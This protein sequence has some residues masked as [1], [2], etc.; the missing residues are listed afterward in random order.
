MKTEPVAPQPGRIIAPDPN[1][2]LSMLKIP[3]FHRLMMAVLACCVSVSV[4]AAQAATDYTRLLDFEGTYEYAQGPTLQIAASP[5]AL[6]LQA[7]IAGA[8]YPLEPTDT[9]DVF[10]NV[11]D[12]RV[13]F[14]RDETGEVTGYRLL[15]DP[16]QP[17]FR[18][19]SADDV[20][21]KSMWYPRLAARDPG[22]RY[23]YTPPASP[24][25]GLPVGGLENS[26][27]T[28]GRV[29]ALVQKIISR[30]YPDVHSVL[31]AAGDKL[32]VEE[33][34]Y[35]YDRDALHQM[36]SATKSV[37]ALL[38]GMA[39]EQG[40]IESAKEPVLPY[41]EDEY[42]DLENVTD[43]K[44]QI[45]IED[46]LTQQS[47]LACNDWDGSSPGNETTM[48]NS[49]DWIRFVLNLPMAHAPGEAASYCSGGVKVLARLVEKQAGMPVEAFAETHLFEPL[50]IRDYR[51][52]FEPDSSSS[53]HFTQLYLR[54]RDM[55]KLGLLVANR[56]AWNEQQVI[57]R[58]W[59][60]SMTSAHSEL[61][62]TEY[63]YLWW[64]PYLNT[65]SGRHDAIAAQGNGGQEIYI[66]PKLNRVVVMTGGN[67]NRQSPSNRIFIEH[68]LPAP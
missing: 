25:P 7:I 49:E 38:V 41:F 33:Y 50:G 58:A 67:Y 61:G 34:F 45:T 37:V 59:I 42:P 16:D 36:R 15:D 44:R 9:T 68:L 56:G 53:H 6:N 47:G 55:L 54:P 57:S 48:G 28:A 39:I 31:V 35:E 11:A 26:G 62:N 30:D 60:S 5:V 23:E 22:Y 52:D 4:S 32:V 27:L 14:E 63:G 17:F 43:E 2:I 66:W 10:T 46:M 1:P 12:D 21:P 8:R 18:R 24:E 40:L 20:F 29:E 64:R 51:W 3:R 65:S 13:A 19:L